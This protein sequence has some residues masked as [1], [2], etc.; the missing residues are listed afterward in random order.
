[1]KVHLSSFFDAK[2]L[3]SYKSLLGAGLVRQILGNL[4][5]FVTAENWGQSKSVFSYNVETKQCIHIGEHGY[6]SHHCIPFLRNS[7]VSFSPELGQVAIHS[8]ITGKRCQVYDQLIKHAQVESRHI[9]DCQTAHTDALLIVAI[10]LTQATSVTLIY[11]RSTQTLLQSI[12]TF[13]S[14]T[15]ASSP[16]APNAFVF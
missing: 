15:C 6:Q 9:V 7:Q 8:A 10:L 2:L 13:S 3:L 4:V 14:V 5:V 12:K 11:Q 1:M 16:L